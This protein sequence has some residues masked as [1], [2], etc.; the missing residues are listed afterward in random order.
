MT[1]RRRLGVGGTAVLAAGLALAG[2]GCAA[3]SSSS[4]PAAPATSASPPPSASP[5]VSASPAPTAAASP[6]TVATTAAASPTAAGASAPTAGSAACTAFASG[7]AFLHLTKASENADG[8]LTVTGN[9]ATMICGGPDDFHY[10]FG[11]GTVTGHVLAGARIQ[12]LN[13]ALQLTPTTP[14]KFP[15][16]LASDMNV[17]VFTYTGPRT[18]ITALSEEFHP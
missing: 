2:T 14:A 3:T 15:G 12:V 5:S 9:T 11:S 16:Y 1:G 4:A 13:A 18:A 8:T 17:R 10:N 6:S 7:H